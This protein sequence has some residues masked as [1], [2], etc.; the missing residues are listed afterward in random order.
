MITNDMKLNSKSDARVWA[1][2]YNLDR[3]QENRLST[4]IWKNK[5]CIGCTI[6]QHV[7]DTITDEEFWIIVDGV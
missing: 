4:W 1:A 5:P 7:L 2:Q 6:D 3:E